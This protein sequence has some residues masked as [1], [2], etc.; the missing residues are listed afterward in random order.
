MVDTPA[1]Y[2]ISAD[3]LGIAWS[4]PFPGTREAVLVES[5]PQFLLEVVTAEDSRA[6]VRRERIYR[7]EGLEAYW[8]GWE[9]GLS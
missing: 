6:G 2:G 4:F 7:A 3:G 5:L 8:K 1:E 9:G